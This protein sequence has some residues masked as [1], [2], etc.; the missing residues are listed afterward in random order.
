MDPKIFEN[1]SSEPADTSPAMDSVGIMNEPGVKSLF[2]IAYLLVFF[3]CVIGN[4]IILVVIITNKSMRTVTN[5]FLANLAIADLLVGVFCVFQNAAHFV[6][7]EHGTWPFGRILCHSYIYFLHMIPNSSAGILVLLSIE[8]FIAVLRPMLVQ[9]LMTKSVLI[10]STVLVWAMSAIMNL[11]Y[12]IAVQYIELFDPETGE[13]HGIC[14]RRFLMMADVNILQVVTVINLVVWYVVPLTLLLIIY[15]TIGFVLMRTTEKYSITRSSQYSQNTSRAKL[16]VT[17]NGTSKK[18]PNIEAVDSRKRVIKL[19]V[20]LVFSF[21]VLS[22]PRYMY[23]T[24]S[25]WRETNAPRCL[26]C[27]S[28]LVQP[29]TF[30]MMFV[31]SGVNPILYAFLSQRFR[32]AIADTLTCA[33]D[34]EKR[35]QQVQMVVRRFRTSEN[36]SSSWNRNGVGFLNNEYT[37]GYDGCTTRNDSLELETSLI[38]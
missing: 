16:I 15:I 12:L 1:T 17:K 13:E 9:D 21:A 27:L 14:T 4:S 36:G 11:P 32:T 25:V 38:S 23:L 35:K 34:K 30:L 22:L 7:F 26:N 18:L 5:F 37:T 19:V 20:V 33:S 28:A 8:R 24:W 29:A 2:L 10:V 3:S 31:I 6:L